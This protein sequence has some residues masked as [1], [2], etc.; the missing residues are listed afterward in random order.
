MDELAETVDSVTGEQEVADTFAKIFN[1]LYNSSGSQQG[2]TDLQD[3]IRGLVQTEDSMNKVNK[4]TTELVKQ[5]AVTL[6]PHKM[7]VS[8]GFTSD[9]L[10]HAPD[11]FFSLIALVFRS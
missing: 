8:H 11:L 3:C 2:M 6:N 5:A 1:N 7:D 10:L 9:A 4:L